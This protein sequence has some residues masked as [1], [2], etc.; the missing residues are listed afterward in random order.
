MQARLIWKTDILCKGGFGKIM[1]C[2]GEETCFVQGS[3]DILCRGGF[4]KLIFCAGED[5]ARR[6]KALSPALHLLSLNVSALKL[7]TFTLYKISTLDL[8]G[9]PQIFP[10]GP[11]LKG[12]NVDLLCNLE[13][14]GHPEPSHFVW[15]K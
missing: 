8:P 11:T 15:K 14:P 7:C 13:D 12:G 3:K 4:G 10:N 2:A 1:F 5:L 6:I 9:C